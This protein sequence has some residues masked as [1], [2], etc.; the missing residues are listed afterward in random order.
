MHWQIS[1]GLLPYKDATEQMEERVAQIYSDKADELVLLVEHPPLY[2][3]GTSAK[4]ADLLEPDKFPVFQTG[5]GGEFTY[6]GPGQR[7]AYVMLDL[8]ERKAQD[9]RLYVQ[10]LEQWIINTLAQFDINGMRKDGRIGIW[11]DTAR[12]EA[13]IAALGIRVRK[14]V[15]YHGIAI[16]LCPDLTNFNGIV[17]CG[18][19]K[20][21]VTSFADL[22]KNVTMQELD[23]ALKDE[24]FKIF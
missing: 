20:Y 1:Q 4:M 15:T 22:G 18:I 23:K 21:G 10:N 9:I 5:R 12:G 13:K 2:T 3:A 17:P 16:N 6:H 24:F 8:K 19:S 11:V 7:V 14:W